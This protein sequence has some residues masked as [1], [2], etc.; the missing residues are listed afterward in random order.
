[1]FNNNP[2]TS[3]IHPELGPVNSVGRPITGTNS[4]PLSAAEIVFKQTPITKR[5]PIIE[6]EAFFDKASEEKPLPVSQ[7]TAAEAMGEIKQK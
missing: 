3:T 2:Q 6:L 1:M 5:D 7:H 4:S